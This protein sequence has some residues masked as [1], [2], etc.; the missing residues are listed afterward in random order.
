MT[1]FEAKIFA[2][3]LLASLAGGKWQLKLDW[4]FHKRWKYYVYIKWSEKVIKYI[5]VCPIPGWVQ[6]LAR[7]SSF[8]EYQKSIGKTGKMP[9]LQSF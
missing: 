5:L 3:S 1:V 4:L 8:Y 2:T 9:T 6:G 7:I